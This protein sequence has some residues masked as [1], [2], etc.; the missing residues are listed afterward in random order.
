MFLLFCGSIYG[1][2]WSVRPTCSHIRVSGG[3][4]QIAVCSDFAQDF[5]AGVWQPLLPVLIQIFKLSLRKSIHLSTEIEKLGAA[6]MLYS[7]IG[8]YLDRSLAVI[9]SIV[10]YSF[11][12]FPQLLQINVGIVPQRTRMSFH[13]LANFTFTDF[14]PIDAVYS[15]TLRKSCTRSLLH[16]SLD[17]IVRLCYSLFLHTRRLDA[18]VPVFHREYLWGNL[19][20]CNSESLS[21]KTH[22]TVN[23]K[24]MYWWLFDHLTCGTACVVA[25]VSVRAR[26]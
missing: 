13:I 25:P 8:R 23:A 14:P 24:S 6:V 3:D 20:R 2:Q 12:V 26:R 1:L 15:G 10:I 11:L 21:S 5:H 18:L 17:V 4:I 22:L 19:E 9:P 16:V 7:R